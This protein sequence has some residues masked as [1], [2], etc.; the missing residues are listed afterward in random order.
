MLFRFEPFHLDVAERRLSRSGE[1]IPLRAKV[2]D[3]LCILVENHGRLVR[4]DELMQRL[5]PDSIVED[6]NLDHN[7]SKLRSALQDGVNGQKFIETVPRQGYRFIAECAGNLYPSDAANRS[8]LVRRCRHIRA[9]N[10]IL[11][12]W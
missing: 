8:T 9:G 10:P 7:I 4:K 6:N 12:H 2:F 11:H 5:W 1:P 3:T